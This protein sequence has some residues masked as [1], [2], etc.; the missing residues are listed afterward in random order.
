MATV[1][2]AA[3]ES[4]GRNVVLKLLKKFDDPSQSQ[5]F[6][7]EGRIIASLNHRNIITI[8]DVGF[9]DNERP[10][11]SME[12]MEGGDLEERLAKGMTADEAL[13]VVQAIGNC[14][15]FVHKKGIVH[16]DIKPGNILF[17]KDGTPILSD[18]GVAKREEYDPNLT[19]EGLA[20]G[21]PYYLSP[22]QAEGMA[23]DGRADIYGLGIVLYEMLTGSKPYS[24][25]THVETIVAHLTEPVPE[26]PPELSRYQG[27]LGKM[28]AKSPDDRFASAD[29][30]VQQVRELRKTASGHRPLGG[31]QAVKARPRSRAVFAAALAVLVLAG[32]G[33]LLWKRHAA[34]QASSA[35]FSSVAE[36]SDSQRIG[37]YL[38][39]A[40]VALKALRLTTPEGDNAYYYYR[41]VL[42]IDPGNGAATEGMEA[43][44][45]RYAD[46]AEQARARFDYAKANNY[47][48]TGLEIQPDNRRLKALKAEAIH[49]WRVREYLAKAKTALEDY[50]LTTPQNDN[51]YYYYQQVLDI[52][53]RNRA[54]S[55]GIA[56]VA[57]RYAE[58]AEGALN[59]F[60][61][62]EAKTMIRLGLGIQ[63]DNQRLQDLKKNTNIVTDAPKRAYDKIKSM[64]D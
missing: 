42:D 24:G 5:R 29:E 7:N 56:A 4:L 40:E 61:Y 55:E 47:I 51:A 54:A 23:V 53:P 10:Y 63:P 26:L 64:F 45:D 41:Q 19:L 17:H 3:Q 46:L 15:S 35:P 62:S 8:Y 14:L 48:D 18:F 9:T 30:M 34:Q 11:I 21:S 6:L 58:L 20:F 28:I 31:K 52:D 13:R 38:G 25:K 59:R 37:E 27:L 12:Y 2:L 39:K 49:S 57:D 33:A 50:R 60:D 22:E 1:Y 36:Q 32:G 43:L 44:G 16:R